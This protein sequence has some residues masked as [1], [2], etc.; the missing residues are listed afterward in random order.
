VTEDEWVRDDEAIRFI[1]RSMVDI[2]YERR[3]AA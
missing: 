3:I 2:A 1:Q